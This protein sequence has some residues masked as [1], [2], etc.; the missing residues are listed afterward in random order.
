MTSTIE[1]D[2]SG[3]AVNRVW[4]P[5]ATD[6]A[7]CSQLKGLGS[8]QYLLINGNLRGVCWPWLKRS[9]TPSQRAASAAQGSDRT[10]L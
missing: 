5:F 1:S 3:A 4:K 6:W 7:T 9:S 8:I 2:G 10:Y